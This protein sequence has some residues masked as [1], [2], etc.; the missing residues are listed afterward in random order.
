MLANICVYKTKMLVC[1]KPFNALQFGGVATRKAERGKGFSRL[2]MEHILAKYPDMPAFLGANPTVTSFYPRFGFRPVQTYR[3]Y[4]NVAI[5]NK[6]SSAIWLTPDDA[7]VLSALHARKTNS[8][9]LDSLNSQ[10]VNRFH[11]ILDYPDAI[12]L[13]PE[14]GAIVIAEQKDDA[15]FIAD[16]IAQ[17]PVSFDT[18]LK[19]LPFCGVQR[20]EFGFCPDQLD[21]SP[22]WTPTDSTK[23]PYFTRGEWN[24]PDNFRFPIMSET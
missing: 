2:L 17:T 20:V 23:A 13:L 19:E 11:L 9:M 6:R 5:D 7:V 16:V 8:N 15:L 12:C 10:P 18:L 4:V 22:E 3:P 14:S 24:M 21:V 1:G